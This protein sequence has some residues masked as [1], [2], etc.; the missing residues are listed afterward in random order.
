MSCAAESSSAPC[1]LADYHTAQDQLYEFV[2]IRRA[3]QAKALAR[4]L[5]M[6]WIVDSGKVP[7][8]LYIR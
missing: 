3:G 1:A 4:T 5:L 2:W 7:S 6:Q 8:G